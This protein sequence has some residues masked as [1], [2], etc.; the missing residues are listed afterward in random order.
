VDA[1]EYLREDLP[2]GLAVHWA[3]PRGFEGPWL[4]EEVAAMKRAV[5][6]RRREFGCGRQLARAGL[7]KL[8]L[9]EGPILPGSD[10]RPMWPSDVVGSIAHCLDACVA[11]VGRRPPFAALGIDVELSGPLPDDLIPAV[12]T[13]SERA[14]WTRGRHGHW[15]KAVFVAKE[16]FYKAQYESTRNFLE[17][18]DVRCSFESEPEQRHLL[19]FRCAPNRGPDLAGRLYDDG[20]HVLAWVVDY[21]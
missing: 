19:G 14:R 18:H 12:T 4:A 10:R 9:P 20:A 7:A 1:F 6:K 15:A 8:G 5:L 3:D 17:F 16:A 21:A 13:S 11:V 2:V